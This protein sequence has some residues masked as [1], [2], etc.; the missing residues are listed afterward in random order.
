MEMR[1]EVYRG[2]V[3]QGVWVMGAL[4]VEEERYTR[5]YNTD[6]LNSFDNLDNT[7]AYMAAILLLWHTQLHCRSC[8]KR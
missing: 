5:G 4:E 3:V 6:S 2:N 8:L 1:N 7:E